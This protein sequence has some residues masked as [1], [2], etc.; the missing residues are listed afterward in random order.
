MNHRRQSLTLP[1]TLAADLSPATLQ[2][3]RWPGLAVYHSFSRAYLLINYIFVSIFVWFSYSLHGANSEL[4]LDPWR[5]KFTCN[6]MPS[7]GALEANE[8]PASQQP[9]T[10]PTARIR[11]PSWPAR[12]HCP[13]R[14]RDAQHLLFS[15]SS[16]HP[17]LDDLGGLRWPPAILQVDVGPVSHTES[18]K[19][20]RRN[21]ASQEF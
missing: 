3:G 4:G 1:F 11:N 20:L 2:D 15:C 5:S 6:G 9:S 13:S 7:V 16:T 10:N 12:P 17:S 14:N 21:C 18:S 8:Y 19:A